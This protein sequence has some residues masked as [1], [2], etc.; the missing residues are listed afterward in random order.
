MKRIALLAALVLPLTAHADEASRRVKAQEMVTLVHVDTLMKQVMD[1][2]E[3]Q[4]ITMA[5]QNAGKDIPP[6]QQARLDA[7]QH[8][9]FAL[10]EDQVSWKAL[11]PD[12]L[13]LYAKTFTDDELDGIIAF[14]KSPAGISMVEKLPGLS[15]QAM[16]IS[17]SRVQAIMPQVQQMIVDFAKESERD[18]QKPAGTSHNLNMPNPGQPH[19]PLKPT[20]TH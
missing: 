17:Q 15:A 6:A 8:K 19:V 3:Q 9:V 20:K 5:R 16:Q 11:G 13:D 2:M 7:F 10:I 4:I 18:A 12:I 14:Y 1:N